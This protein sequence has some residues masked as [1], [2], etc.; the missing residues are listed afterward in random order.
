MKQ[1]L[2]EL[3]AK[4]Y[5]KLAKAGFED[6]EDVSSPREFLKEWH[7]SW[8]RSRGHTDQFLA[9]ESYFYPAGHFLTNYEFDNEVERKVWAFHSE[10]LSLREIAARMRWKSHHKATIIIKKLRK[11][12]LHSDNIETIPSYR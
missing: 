7:G 10:G 4:W 5:K 6:I 2:K 1:S 8:F 3:Q 9:K 12:M 11:E